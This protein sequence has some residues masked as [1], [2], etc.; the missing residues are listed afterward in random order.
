MKRFMH[1]YNLSC[2]CLAGASGVRCSPGGEPSAL[3]AAAISV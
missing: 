2:V 3:N 1:F